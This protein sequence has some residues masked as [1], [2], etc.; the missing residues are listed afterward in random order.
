[1]DDKDVKNGETTKRVVINLGGMSCATC[2]AKVEKALSA[3]PGVTTASVN[4]ASEKA[5]GGNRLPH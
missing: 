1:M 5:S 2:A 3:I 4:F